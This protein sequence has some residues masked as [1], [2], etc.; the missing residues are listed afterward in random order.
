MPLTRRR[1]TINRGTGGGAREAAVG[2][3]LCISLLV[4]LAHRFD[5]LLRAGTVATMA[6]LARL[7][8]VTRARVTQI[9]GLLL[10]APDIQEDLLR[11]H[12]A[13]HRDPISLCELR[14]VMQ[15]PVWEEQRKRWAGIRAAWPA[16]KKSS[17]KVE[18]ESVA[19]PLL[20]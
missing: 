10:L 19:A 14:Y 11:L 4:A 18:I 13:E 12:L 3:I 9:L 8:H 15:A 5:G 7:G 20:T 17:G 16:A 1:P 6:D 2:L